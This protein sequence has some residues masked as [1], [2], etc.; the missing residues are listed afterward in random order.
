MRASRLVAGLATVTTAMLVAVAGPAAAVV[1]TTTGI[2][3]VTQAPTV[4][5]PGFNTACTVANKLQNCAEIR[6]QT[7]VGSYMV[8]GG[9]FQQVLDPST[10]K[11]LIDPATGV[12]IALNN[13]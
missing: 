6:T 13:L 5:T 10:G 8:L 2:A 12:A 3:T 4:S 9:S 1:K 11:A 7:Q